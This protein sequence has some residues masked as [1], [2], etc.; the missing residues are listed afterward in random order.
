MKYGFTAG[1]TGTCPARTFL[2]TDVGLSVKIQILKHF[3]RLI[4]KQ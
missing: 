3:R 1:D 4:E 2:W